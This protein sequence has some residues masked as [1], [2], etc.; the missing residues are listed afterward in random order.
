MKKINFMGW[1]NCL[2]IN[3]GNFKLIITTE[4]GPRIIGGFLN[5]GDNLF[6]VDPKT[7]DNNNNENEW[8]IYGGHRLWHAPE[9]MP[10][11][12]EPDNIPVA[13]DWD[14]KSDIVW[15]SSGT[16]PATGIHKSFTIEPLGNEKF[17]IVH[18]IK[19]DNMWEI[20]LAAW[21]LSVMAPGGVGVIPQ[22]QGDKTALLPNRNLTL[23]PYTNMADPRLTWGE[24]YTLLRQDPQA[25][26][27]CKIGFNCE[28]GWL[29]YVNNGT[30]LIK[31]FEHL[32]DAEYPDNGCSI[33]L[34]TNEA[35]EEI[36][37]LSPLYNL[38]P[39]ETI[40]HIEE[41]EAKAGFGTIKTEADAERYFG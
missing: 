5:N 26:T 16:A 33:E 1:K 23:W 27:P 11:T 12:Y 36:E 34:Y 17:R 21:A 6:Y 3:S 2:E 41:W 40:I 39:G 7:V 22:P 37:T 8:N 29:A 24:K 10:R 15:V 14:E 20:E 13:W 30:A 19:N 4:I 9:A 32:I 35:M 18:S 31:R 25:T 38:G 28:D